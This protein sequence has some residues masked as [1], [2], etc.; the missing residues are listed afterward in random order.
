MTE[1]KRAWGVGPIIDRERDLR[2][3]LEATHLK[4]FGLYLTSRLK[5]EVAELARE[6]MYRYMAALSLD[7]VCYVLTLSLEGETGL[8]LHKDIEAAERQAENLA[9]ALLE[10]G[11][12]W[13]P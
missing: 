4:L 9:R 12:A 6:R 10:G 11:G 7:D 8:Y 13:L 1:A 3:H 2:H 5:P